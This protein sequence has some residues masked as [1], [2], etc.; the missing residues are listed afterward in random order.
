[1]TRADWSARPLWVRKIAAQAWS[2]GYAEGGDIAPHG[3]FSPADNR[4]ALDL[5]DI[6]A[7]V[8]DERVDLTRKEALAKW[9][10]AAWRKYE[11]LFGQ[12]PHGTEKQLRAMVELESALRAAALEGGG[13]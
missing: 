11:F 2:D 3:F 4:F 1:M 13:E 7:P 6:T 8:A 10:I 12:P 5:P 9:L